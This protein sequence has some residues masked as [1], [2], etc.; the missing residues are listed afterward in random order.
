MN[1]NSLTQIVSLGSALFGLVMLIVNLF[2]MR[3]EAWLKPIQQGG[4]KQA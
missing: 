4:G 3:K 1:A 2:Q